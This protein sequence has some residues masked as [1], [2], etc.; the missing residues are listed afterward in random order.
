[1]LHEIAVFVRSEEALARAR[2]AIEAA[3]VQFK[4]L[5]E[6]SRRPAGMFHSQRCRSPR[7]SSFAPWR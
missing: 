5:D 7:A 6:R 3:G 1:M 4:V 2:G